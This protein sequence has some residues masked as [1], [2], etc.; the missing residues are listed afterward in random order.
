MGRLFDPMRSEFSQLFA[1]AKSIRKLPV[2]IGIE[3]ERALFAD[4][5]AQHGGSAH[6]PTLILRP[7]LQ[8][9]CRESMIKSLLREFGY[10]HVVIIHPAH[11]C[12]IAGISLLQDNFPLRTTRDLR[13]E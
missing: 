5:F 10:L 4:Q 9:E 2:L 11:R 13:F 12:V 6:V 7:D 8:L 1:Y 3:H